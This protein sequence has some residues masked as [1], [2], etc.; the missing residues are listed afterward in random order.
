MAWRPRAAIQMPSSMLGY[1][2]GAVPVAEKSFFWPASHSCVQTWVV[3][4]RFDLRPRGPKGRACAFRPRDDSKRCPA[5]PSLERLSWY[6]MVATY[7]KTHSV[8]L[9]HAKIAML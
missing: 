3:V 6:R 7:P 4:P 2:M 5:R 9:Q 8:L 1:I